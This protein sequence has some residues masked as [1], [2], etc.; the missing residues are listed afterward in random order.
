MLSNAQ[1]GET[2][3]KPRENPKSGEKYSKRI[4]ISLLT[5][6]YQCI[7]IVPVNDKQHLER[8]RQ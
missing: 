8:G 5:I 6:G 1:Q 3:R 2:P 4:L 7:T